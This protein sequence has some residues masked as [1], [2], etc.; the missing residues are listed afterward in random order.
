MANPQNPESMEMHSLNAGVGVQRMAQAG[1]DL[2]MAMTPESV[3]S[4]VQA[5]QRVMSAVM[6]RGTHYDVIPGTE[7][8]DREGNDISKPVLLKPGAEVLCMTFGLSPRTRSVVTGDHPTIAYAYKDRKKKWFNGANGR[9][10]EW[11]DETGEV[12]GYFEVLATCEIYGPDGRLL[13][14]AEGSANNREK[15]Y[16][17]QNV[18]EVRNTILKMAGKRAFLAATLMATG[19]S[20]MFTQDLEDHDPE[21][22][23]QQGRQQGQQGRQQGRGAAPQGDAAGSISDPQKRLLW[24]KAKFAGVS[25][26]AAKLAYTYYNAQPKSNVRAFLDRIAAK[27]ATKEQVLE[28]FKPF[29]D[30]AAK[31]AAVGAG[32]PPADPAAPADGAPATP[33]RR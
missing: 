30:E 26:E 1:D 6:K 29:I 16:R 22:D 2:L 20:D 32:T 12:V 10:F 17:T 25:E 24:G 31:N 14:S 4:R 3:K 15:R 28:A 19:A 18:Y 7:K 9:D 21:G 27:D 11:T 23:P 8:V 5:I 33:G 13:A